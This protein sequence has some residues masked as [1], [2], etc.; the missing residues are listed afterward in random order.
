MNSGVRTDYSGWCSGRRRKY[1]E[2]VL[3]AVQ[4]DHTFIPAL[5]KALVANGEHT[6]KLCKFGNQLEL[7]G[8][9]DAGILVPLAILCK[10]DMIRSMNGRTR[11]V[12]SRAP[13]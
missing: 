12:D 5:E 9:F 8:W 1:S 2:R 3:W 4:N 13:Q 6:C 10:R 11:I 7:Y